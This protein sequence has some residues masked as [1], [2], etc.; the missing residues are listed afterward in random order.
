MELEQKKMIA[1]KNQKQKTLKQW[2]TN[3]PEWDLAVSFSFLEDNIFKNTLYLF[4]QFAM[5]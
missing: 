3:I 5:I 2:S 4:V 1:L